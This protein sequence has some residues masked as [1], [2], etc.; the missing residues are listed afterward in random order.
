LADRRKK[1]LLS[2]RNRYCKEP[3]RRIFAIA[4]LMAQ[5]CGVLTVNFAGNAITP[6]QFQRNCAGLF[7][8]LWCE[9]RLVRPWLPVTP[10]LHLTVGVWQEGGGRFCLSIF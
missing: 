6:M 9:R 7:F 4:T 1:F 10:P 8:E 3:E 5:L 2:R